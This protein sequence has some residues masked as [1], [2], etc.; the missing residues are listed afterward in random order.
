MRAEEVASGTWGRKGETDSGVHIQGTSGRLRGPAPLS[1]GWKKRG[2]R[3]DWQRCEQ[4]VSKV[5]C[6]VPGTKLE[7]NLKGSY[8][9]CIPG[10]LHSLNNR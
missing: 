4:L 10:N 7:H 8:D 9:F 6:K 5:L 1:S 2:G 3:E